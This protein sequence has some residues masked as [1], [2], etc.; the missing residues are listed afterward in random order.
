MST[1]TAEP[2]FLFGAELKPRFLFGE[3][4]GGSGGGCQV[5][6]RQRAFSCGD[7]VDLRVVGRAWMYSPM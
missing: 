1:E 7:G 4:C 2:S 3:I 5:G 6:R